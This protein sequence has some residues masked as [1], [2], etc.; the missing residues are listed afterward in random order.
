MVKKYRLKFYKV[1][2]LQWTGKNTTEVKYFVGPDFR[3]YGNN[4]VAYYP[5]SEQYRSNLLYIKT[6]KGESP[7]TLNVD[8]YVIKYEEGKLNILTQSDF[9]KMYQ[10]VESV[11]DE[12]AENN[13]DI[14]DKKEDNEK[15]LFCRCHVAGDVL[16]ERDD[17][18]FSVEFERITNI[19]FCPKCGRRLNEEGD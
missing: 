2:A 19:K 6:V 7:V 1:E 9:E 11:S 14:S 18:D 3:G 12:D 8:D 17:T 16:Y 13:K 4:V 15:C 10:E 5:T